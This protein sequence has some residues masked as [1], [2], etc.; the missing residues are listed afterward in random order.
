MRL[1]LTPLLL[2]VAIFTSGAANLTSSEVQSLALRNIERAAALLDAVWSTSVSGRST[3]LKLADNY[4]TLTRQA[5][6]P[7]DVWPYTAAIEGHVAILEAL[8]A[9]REVAPELYAMRY[10]VFSSR[11][12][13]LIDNLE[14]YRGTYRLPSYA[15][16]REWSPYAVPRAERR[17]TANVT[18]VLNVYDD[19]MWLSRELIRAY[20]VTGNREYLDLATYLADYVIDGWDCWRDEH[21]NE[22]GGITW[23]PGYNSK[24]AC[25]NAPMIQPL[26]WLAN[27]YADT[28]ST[29]LHYYRDSLNQVV[30]VTEPRSRVYL[31]FAR[32]IYDWQKS[33]L[34]SPEGLYWDM[35]GAPSE[36]KESQGYRLHVDTGDPCGNF[37][38]YNTGTMIAGAAELYRATR[39]KS[40][41]ADLEKTVPASFN[42]FARYIPEHGTY[43]FATDATAE[44]GFNTWFN[45]V[46]MRSYYDAAP[47]VENDSAKRGL[48]TFQTTLDYAF[49]N[50]NRD[51]LLPIRLLQ[52]WGNETITKAFHQSTFAA[53]YALLA[54]YYLKT[55]PSV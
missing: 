31:Q 41:L 28:D 53:Q 23:G 51:N 32:K 25:S 29:M 55:A 39:E 49:E 18:G 4:N 27:I 9:A 36:I 42:H 50:H 48:G 54:I 11:L 45:N 33:H 7:A 44:N 1:L 8:Q 22:Y 14:Y 3:D 26:V 47:L 24:H 38:S 6:G 17:G 43:Q 40:Y 21:G 12:E 35:M 5:S 19:Q 37:Y 20:R 10:P 30:A 46:L 15:S 16:N 2:F 34:A 13:Q 52:G